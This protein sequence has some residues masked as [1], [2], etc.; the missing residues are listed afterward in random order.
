MQIT[1]LPADSP[2]VML[3]SSIQKPTR[4]E[5]KEVRS[6]TLA[7][8]EES[9]KIDK[10]RRKFSKDSSDMSHTPPSSNSIL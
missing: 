1:S 10:R 7:C 9:G 3:P 5:E 4:E 8:S 2:A 6:A